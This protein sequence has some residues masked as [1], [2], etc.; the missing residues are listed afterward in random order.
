MGAGFKR[1]RLFLAPHR[2]EQDR[3]ILQTLG[4]VRMH[5]AQNL[6]AH[7][8]RASI[9]GLSIGVPPLRRVELAQVAKS[10][11]HLHMVGPVDLLFDSQ[12]T[13]Q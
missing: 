4:H 5:V 13:L 11:S 12:G 2:P 1:Q 9:V 3:I 6:F 10:D 7:C 8:Q